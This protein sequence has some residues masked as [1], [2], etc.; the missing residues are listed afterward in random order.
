MIGAKTSRVGQVVEGWEKGKETYSYAHVC[1]EIREGVTYCEDRE[2][3][4]SIRESKDETK[5]LCR[6]SIRWEV[7]IG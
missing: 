6:S 1:Y 5:C 4:Y 7:C 3:D 2:A